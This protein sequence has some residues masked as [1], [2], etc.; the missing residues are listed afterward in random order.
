MWRT[1]EELKLDYNPAPQV[2]F[3]FREI[4]GLIEAVELTL[5][6]FVM[7]SPLSAVEKPRPH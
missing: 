4:R 1:L 2:V 7:Q 3:S 5:G 6:S